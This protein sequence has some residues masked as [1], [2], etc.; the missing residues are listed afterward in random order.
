MMNPYVTVKLIVKW[1]L[2]K[3]LKIW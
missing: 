2:G 1:E 3:R